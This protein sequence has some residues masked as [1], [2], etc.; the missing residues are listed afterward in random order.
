MDTKKLAKERALEATKEEKQRRVK[1]EE[2]TG[3]PGKGQKDDYAWYCRRCQLEFVADDVTECFK[4]HKDLLSRKERHEEIMSRVHDLV[5]EKELRKQRRSLHELYLKRKQEK[6]KTVAT[7]A[8]TDYQAWDIYEP[9]SDSDDDQ[10]PDTEAF[11]ALEKDVEERSKKRQA[12]IK[13]ANEYKEK[14]NAFIAQ[15]KYN[16]AI[17]WYSRA[18]ETYRGEKVFHANRY[19]DRSDSYQIDR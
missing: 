13:E 3:R 5:K 7:T 17:K 6:K 14:G 9:E 4:C 10:P 11:R 2:R 8:V 15:K 12:Q 18:I 16:N 19:V 1:E